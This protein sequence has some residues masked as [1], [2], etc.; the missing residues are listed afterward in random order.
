LQHLKIGAR[1]VKWACAIF[2]CEV[3]GNMYDLHIKLG[4]HSNKL[5]KLAREAK[6]KNAKYEALLCSGVWKDYAEL[7]KLADKAWWADDA[8]N[9]EL[10][11]IL[12]IPPMS[13]E[14]AALYY[15]NCREGTW[16]S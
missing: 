6:S 2:S 13:E 7:E 16:H 3:G 12:G 14:N 4:I 11:R 8:Y 10:D 1:S 5:D 15:G 9:I